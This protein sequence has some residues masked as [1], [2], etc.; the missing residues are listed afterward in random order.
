MFVKGKENGVT[1]RIERRGKSKKS[2]KE[3]NRKGNR[4]KVEK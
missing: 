1:V 2:E 4:E 3:R